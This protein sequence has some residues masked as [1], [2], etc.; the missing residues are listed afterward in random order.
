M[1]RPITNRAAFTASF[2]ASSSS[3]TVPSSLPRPSAQMRSNVIND[4]NDHDQR[5]RTARSSL[6]SGAIQRVRQQAGDETP[7]GV[8][9]ARAARQALS[10]NAASS[11]ANRS[12]I[13]DDSGDSTAQLV[14]GR[15]DLNPVLATIDV[16]NPQMPGLSQSVAPSASTL[17]TNNT[18]ATSVDAPA[19]SSTASQAAIFGTAGRRNGADQPIGGATVGTAYDFSKYLDGELDPFN[20]ASRAN[21]R[22]ESRP[23]LQP[24]R[25]MKMPTHPETPLRAELWSQRRRRPPRPSSRRPSSA[26]SRR[27]RPQHRA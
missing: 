5:A 27:Q 26:V 13:A 14:P 21:P 16:E 8:S 17:A 24:N 20:R 23:C 3:N 15:R 18:A 25:S 6:T 9:Q 10:A 19:D 12:L 4:E 22:R 7:L 2:P 1:S 11:Q